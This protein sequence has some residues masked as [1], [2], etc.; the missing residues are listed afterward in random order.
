LAEGLAPAQ[1]TPAA[2]ANTVAV[3][4]TDMKFAS[5]T[6]TFVVGRPYTFVVTNRGATAHEMVIEK[7]GV[8]DQPLRS[9]DQEAEASNV[10]PGQ[11]KTLT[12]TFA[13]P[14]EYQ[15]ACLIPGHYEAGMVLDIEV[16]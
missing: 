4:M 15:L 10:Q 8:V 5:S 11:T 16:T 13:E 7:R 2:S 9:G 14:G 3:T 12:W 1:A 6:T